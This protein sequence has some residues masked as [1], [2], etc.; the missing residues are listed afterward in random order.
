MERQKQGNS[1]V[2]DYKAYINNLDAI[3][4]LEDVQAYKQK[5]LVIDHP[6]RALTRKIQNFGCDIIQRSKNVTTQLL[7]FKEE[8]ATYFT[9]TRNMSP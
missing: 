1:T 9:V 8:R 4:A 2:I 7:Y 3:N 5:T 6:A